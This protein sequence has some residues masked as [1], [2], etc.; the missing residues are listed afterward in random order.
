MTPTSNNTVPAVD[1]VVGNIVT[2]DDLA[3]IIGAIDGA[4][5]QISA[6]HN[7]LKF[8]ILSNMDSITANFKA[9]EDKGNLSDYHEKLVKAPLRGHM[10]RLLLIGR[11]L[12]EVSIKAKEKFKIKS[13]S[14]SD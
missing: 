14:N 12:E 9:S 6:I 7:E 1:L 2:N 3:S 8:Q 13:D 5:K 4:L 10:K 11:S